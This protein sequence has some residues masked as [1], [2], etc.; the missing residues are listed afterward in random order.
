MKFPLFLFLMCVSCQCVFE[1]LAIPED[2]HAK[3]TAWS[4][5]GECEMNAGYML[6]SCATSCH[7]YEEA[8]A[9]ATP[10]DLYR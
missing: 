6:K 2:Q 3:C 4:Y 7:E 10:D 5:L 8:M 9:A 1:A